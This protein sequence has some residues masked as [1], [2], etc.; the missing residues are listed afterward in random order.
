MKLINSGEYTQF[1]RVYG[2]HIYIYMFGIFFATGVGFLIQSFLM[3][4][5]EASPQQSASGDEKSNNTE[6]K[7][8]QTTTN[9]PTEKK[10]EK[11]SEQSAEPIPEKKD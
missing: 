2:K 11:A 7:E 5:E 10:E 3:P 6:K 1:G 8:N 4:K 9:A